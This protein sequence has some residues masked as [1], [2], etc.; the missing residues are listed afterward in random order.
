MNFS[1]E[2]RNIFIDTSSDISKLDND[3]LK[4]IAPKI[5]QGAEILRDDVRDVIKKTQSAGR[6]YRRGKNK[7]HIASLPGYPPNYDTGKLWEGTYYK[8]VSGTLL[9]HLEAVVGSDPTRVGAEANYAWYLHAG[10]KKMHARPFFYRTILKR[11][12]QEGFQ[13]IINQI[14]F[15][16]ENSL[17]AKLV[18]PGRRRV[19]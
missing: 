4:A 1:V 3:V 2:Q 9:S 15:V 12:K 19:V 7:W 17:R 11:V 6:S 18:R 16:V 13:K 10:T 8:P 14:R 5:N